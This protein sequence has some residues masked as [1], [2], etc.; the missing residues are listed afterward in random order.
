MRVEEVFF[1]DM[2][3][4][5]CLIS[6]AGVVALVNLRDAFDYPP[7]EKLDGFL[8]YAYIDG[9]TFV[10]EVL[11][12]ARLEAN[13]IKVFPSSYKK[14]V[15]LK[16]GQVDAAEIKIV[17]SEYSLPFRDRIA[18]ITDRTDADDA[19]EQTRLIKNLDAFRHP[20]YPDDVVVYFFSAEHKPELLW[21]RCVSVDENILAGELLNEPTKDFG[22]HAG[23][24][25]KFGVAQ[26]NEQ[27]ILLNL[28]TN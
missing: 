4:Q 12:G 10:F 21:V 20:H 28:P 9:E 24:L 27:N 25:I 3:R 2:Y 5:I 7:D 6:G 19:K 26:I 23:D 14:S 11:A 16:R 8:T 1:R 18:I 22:C 17:T 13:R 15:K